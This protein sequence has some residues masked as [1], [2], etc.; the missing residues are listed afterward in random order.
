[1]RRMLALTAV[2]GL[3]LVMVGCGG[4]GQTLA[5]PTI[6]PAAQYTVAGFRPTLPVKVGQPTKIAFTLVQPDGTPL[7]H[8]RTGPGPHTGVHLILARNDLA[9]IIHRHPPISKTGRV[10]DTVTFTEPGPYRV[11][12][13][14][15]PAS[16]GPGYTNFQLTQSLRV[17]GAYTP[18][19]LPPFSPTVVTQGYTFTMHHPPVL[20]TA[21][22]ALIDVTVRD[23]DGKPAVFTPWFGALAHAIFFHKTDL[24]YFHTHVCAPGLAGCTSLVGGAKVSGTSTKPGVLHVGVLVPEP[25]IWRLFLQCQVDGKILTAPFTLAVR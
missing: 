23:P 17:K 2:L 9:T 3:A 8:Y 19:P 25:G 6:A 11:L 4:G 20:H 13:D 10:Q 15:Y 24:A 16:K 22:A 12:I 5:P 14:V 7:V 18:E 21:E 1:M